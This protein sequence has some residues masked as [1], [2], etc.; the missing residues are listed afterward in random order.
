MSREHVMIPRT[1]GLLL[2]VSHRSSS[3]CSVDL[4]GARSTLLLRGL[5]HLL[6]Y[7][8][9][10]VYEALRTRLSMPRL[11]EIEGAIYRR[12]QHKILT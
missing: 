4:H 3:L 5:E 2:S 9:L 7:Q 11:L 6:I 8:A 12:I 10:Q 1:D